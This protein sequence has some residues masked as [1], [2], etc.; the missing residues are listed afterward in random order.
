M[1][2]PFVFN[3][4]V[5]FMRWDLRFRGAV[6]EF[7]GISNYLKAFQDA[8]FIN[9]LSKTFYLLSVA[10]PLEFFIGLILA[11]M[12]FEPF[13]MRR[14]LSAV[15]LFPLALS[16]AVVGLVWGLVLVPTYGPLDLLMRTFGLWDLL[17]F[18]KPISLVTTYP[19][20]MIVLADVW[21]WTPFFFLVI[22]AG[23]ASIPK[24]ILESA[25][26]DGASRAKIMRHMMI[27]LIKPIIGVA[28]IIRLMDVFK[29]FGI[30]YVM[31]KGG[32]GFASEVAS[33]YIFNQA[34]QFLNVAYAA[35]LTILMIVIITIILTVFVR[36]YGI[37]F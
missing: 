17:G 14:L 12:F 20:E 35:T 13:R 22:L 28:L 21:Q 25:E 18:K 19:M 1:A 37:K 7:I 30:P 26:I 5:S 29:A 16:E 8:R 32:P 33:L 36:G 11:M 4:Y 10:V 24:E 15:I 6:P 3:L 34:L 23:F 9:S 31:T 27:P 2:F